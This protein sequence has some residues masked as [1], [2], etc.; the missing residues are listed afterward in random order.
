MAPL[1][2]FCSCLVM[3]NNC[4]VY[5]AE[6]KLVVVVMDPHRGLSLRGDATNA[7]PL[8]ELGTWNLVISVH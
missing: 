7:L 3:Y 8:L 4:S 5:V 6:N 2:A 1:V